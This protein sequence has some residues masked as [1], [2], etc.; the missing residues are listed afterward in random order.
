MSDFALK[1]QKQNHEHQDKQAHHPMDSIDPHLQKNQHLQS[2]Q[3]QQDQ[4][5]QSDHHEKGQHD[6]YHHFPSIK[7]FQECCYL[8]IED[9][10][11]KN[12][13]EEKSLVLE[14]NVLLKKKD[15]EGDCESFFLK[16]LEHSH[17]HCV[18]LEWIENSKELSTD[19]SCGLRI[20]FKSREASQ[21]FDFQSQSPVSDVLKN[22]ELGRKVVLIVPL[23]FFLFSK[24]S[25]LSNQFVL[26]DQSEV[27]ES[28]VFDRNQK[29]LSYTESVFSS[30]EICVSEGLS[31]DL[32]IQ[33]VDSSSSFLKKDQNSQ[34]HCLQNQ[35]HG[36]AIYFRYLLKPYSQLKVTESFRGIEKS[37][38]NFR[39]SENSEDFQNSEN[40]ANSGN[41]QNFEETQK[42]QKTQHF[43]RQA[44]V[45]LDKNSFWK[46][47]MDG[48]FYEKDLFDQDQV[49]R[50]FTQKIKVHLRGEG[51]RVELLGAFDQGVLQRWDNH[52]EIDHEFPKTSSYQLY[53]A[54]VRDQSHHLCRAEVCIQEG[55]AGSQAHQMVKGLL[56]NSQSK[57]DCKPLLD[58][59]CDD[60]KATHGVAVSSFDPEHLF[61]FLSRGLN[62]QKALELLENSFLQEVKDL[63]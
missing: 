50:V 37:F 45:F 4:Q 51:A 13:Q 27:F 21:D 33:Y 5:G 48:Q 28:E 43:V 60:V 30:Y 2:D 19:S 29:N 35:N 17:S 59:R 31:V 40:S 42:T 47:F 32:T 38:E 6:D 53:K 12:L 39:T 10:L 8:N 63:V 14:K 26:L 36:D 22:S 1:G 16:P 58:I 57:I 18:D 41:I 54:V 44:C 24:G 34:S 55:A 7:G 20:T 49:S 61:Y 3:G 11:M 56:L 9:I 23:G 15:Q 25:N 46:H 52:T 62:S